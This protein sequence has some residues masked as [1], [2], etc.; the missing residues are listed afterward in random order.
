MGLRFRILARTDPATADRLLAQAEKS[1][2][3]RV[4]LYQSLAALRGRE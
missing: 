3:R 1:N 4:W 2:A